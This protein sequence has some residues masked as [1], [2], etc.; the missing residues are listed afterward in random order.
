MVGPNKILTVSYGTFSCTLEGFD[1]PFGTMQAIAEYFRDLAAQDRYF[2]A[3]PPTP[4]AEMLHSIAEREIQRRVDAK[5]GEDGVVLRPHGA[6]ATGTA[7]ATTT[8]AQP[9]AADPAAPEA[10]A[11]EVVRATPEAAD[12]EQA[13]PAAAEAGAAADA[14]HDAITDKLARIRGAVA[15]SQADA[16]DGAPHAEPSD[17]DQAEASVPGDDATDARDG[18]DADAADADAAHGW[19]DVAAPAAAGAAGVGAWA[20]TPDDGDAAAAPHAGTAPADEPADAEAAATP[21]VPDPDIDDIAAR[22]EAALPPRDARNAGAAPDFIGAPAQDD[23]A[24]YGLFDE[25]DDTAAPSDDRSAPGPAEAAQDTPFDETAFDAALD[26]AEDDAAPAAAE[27]E[28]PA[29]AADDMID[30]DSFDAEL[31]RVVS[32]K[33]AKDAERHSVESLRSEIREVLGDTGLGGGSTDALVDELAQIEQEAVVRHPDFVRK[34]KKK[35][36]S[37]TDQTAERLMETAS[38]ELGERDAKR[39]RDAFEHMKVAVAA[40][41]AEEAAQGPRRRDISEER[42]ISRYREGLDAPEFAA[43]SAPAPDPEPES[44]PAPDPAP[45]TPEASADAAPQAE[46]AARD[47]TPQAEP[48]EDTPIR[49][50]RPAMA[51]GRRHERPGQSKTPLVLVSEQ[52]VDTAAEN[53]PVRPRRVRA[54]QGAASDAVGTDAAPDAMAGFKKFADEV[55]AW[56]LD[57][58]IEAAAAYATHTLGQL[59]FGRPELMDFVIAYNDGKTISREDMLRAFGTLLREGRLE[60]AST[61]KFRL[62]EGSEYAEPARARAQG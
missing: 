21:P 43:N 46:A 32:E 19:R 49:P 5:V 1:E 28:A 62:A 57:D 45:A 11:P 54:N 29:Q 47:T 2:G 22:A 25:D 24:D 3:E 41:R 53:A 52:R 39:R 30:E 20:L 59:E 31:D 10:P 16:P 55:D 27:H 50:R 58:Q 40:T 48:T 17:A 60:R 26:E 35:L 34:V 44:T 42:A 13:A 9:Q 6:A 38:A 14:E 37:D 51:G 12:P 23:F 15:R 61:G 56:L 7:L 8:Q 4:D 36:S 33:A 18:A